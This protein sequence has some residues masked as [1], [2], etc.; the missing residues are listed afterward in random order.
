MRIATVIGN[1]PQ[2]VKAAAVSHRLRERAE[3]VLV[4]TGQHYDDALSRVFFDELEL[5]RPEHRLE[6]GGGSNTSQTARMLSALEPLL[7]A[8][9]ADA[10]LVYG[11]TNS[12]LAGALAG[13]QAGIPVAHVEA[14]MRS[15]DRTMP[16]ELNRVLADHASSL[17]L[18]SSQAAAETLRAERVAG[19]VAVVGDVMVDVFE[20]LAPRAD[21][22]T[23]AR[24]GVE[25][26]GYL[27][28]TAHRAGNVD[29]PKRL[30]ALVE[31]LHALPGPVVLP[32]HP[33]T[34]ARVREAALSLDGVI[35]APPLGYL[36]FAALLLGA[37]RVLTD[38]GGVQKE[39]YLAGVPCITLRA[40]TE[41]R[42]TVQAGWNTLVDLDAP[43]ALAAL[44]REPPPDRPPL[45]GDGRAGERVVDA[46][47]RMV[48]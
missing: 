42:E 15:Y 14:G 36:E 18:C 44:T 11:D 31:L 25:P 26:G 12:T 20:L 45:Y 10:V 9:R 40:T 7:A 6:L 30:A 48:A 29:D 43:A 21:Q 5:P 23:L 22:A 3:E 35:V 32:L 46:L 34:R 24:L 16:E 8:E 13:A 2:F 19:E 28:A 39:A 37:R 17:L 1:R 27:L 38:S 47:L 41:W 33:R 4:H